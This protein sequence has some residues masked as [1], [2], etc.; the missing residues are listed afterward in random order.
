MLGGESCPGGS[1]ALFRD[2]TPLGATCICGDPLVAHEEPVLG[3][4]FGSITI[5]QKRGGWK[6]HLE[7]SGQTSGPGE[8]KFR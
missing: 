6:E 1:S 7:G 5:S 2:Q 8:G 4:R 3:Q